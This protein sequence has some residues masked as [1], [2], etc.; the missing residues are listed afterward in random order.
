LKKLYLS[1][2]IFYEFKWRIKILVILGSYKRYM[3]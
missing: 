1:K 2:N 3:P